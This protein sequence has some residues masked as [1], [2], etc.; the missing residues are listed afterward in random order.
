MIDIGFAVVTLLTL[1]LSWDSLPFPTLLE[2][3]RAT[4][5]DRNAHLKQG[6]R[7]LLPL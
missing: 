4:L 7:H 3:F 6:D 2:K 1:Y 5:Q